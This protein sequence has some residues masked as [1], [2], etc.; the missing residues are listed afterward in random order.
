MAAVKF[1]R[2]VDVNNY[3]YKLS[4][5]IY[6]QQS[7]GFIRRAVLIIGLAFCS[8]L[9]AG[10]SAEDIQSLRDLLQPITSLSAQF[11]QRITDAEGFQLDSSRGLFEVAQPAKLRWI[12]V[13]PLPQQII[14]DGS[15]LWVYDPDLEQVIIQPF[16][17]DIA[18]TPAILFSGDLDKLDSAYYVRED[19]PGLFTLTPERAGSLFK[20]MQIEFINQQPVSIAL[21]DNLEQTTEIT[22][23]ELQV[24]PRIS[25][26]RFDFEIPATV[27]VINNLENRPDKH[28]N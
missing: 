22:F 19:S 25:A 16:N 24:N 11:T 23:A 28:A 12:V 27:D 20:S 26:D 8:Q 1:L 5:T 13:E 10:G 4:T 15:T 14:S 18:A 2:L 7:M 3:N 21:T 17:Q 9:Q 6:G